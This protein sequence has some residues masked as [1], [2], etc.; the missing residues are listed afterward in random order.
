MPQYN[1]REALAA[2]HPH[3]RPLHYD[4]QDAKTVKQ[5]PLDDQ[6]YIL[7]TLMDVLVDSKLVRNAI[8][9]SIEARSGTLHQVKLSHSNHHQK[10]TQGSSCN[11]QQGSQDVP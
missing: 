2:P 9:N 1:L 3:L 4:L 11:T 8:T 7:R 5:L 10:F 6:L